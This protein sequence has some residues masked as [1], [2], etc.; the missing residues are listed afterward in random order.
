[1]IPK[2]DAKPVKSTRGL[3]DRHN[4]GLAKAHNR[5]LMQSCPILN[6]ANSAYP[7]DTAVKYGEAHAAHEK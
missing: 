6:Y 2:D 1:M 4:K 5:E 3:P 7:C